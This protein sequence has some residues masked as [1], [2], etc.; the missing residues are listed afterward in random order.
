MRLLLALS[1]CLGLPLGASAQGY[2]PAHERGASDPASGTEL[3][4]V[5]LGSS[6][7]APCRDARFKQTVER[8]KNLLAGR[9]EREGARF[10]TMGVALDH[11]VDD[12]LAFL[13]DSGRWDEVAAGRNWLNAAALAHVWRPDGLEGRTVALPTVVVFE[14]DVEVGDAVAASAPRYLGEWVGAFAIPDWVE[15]GAPLGDTRD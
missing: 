12:G 6:T 4:M 2:V 13:Q 1:L 14:R 3:V 9:A 15:A 10:A 7:C 8:A 11:N 5:Y